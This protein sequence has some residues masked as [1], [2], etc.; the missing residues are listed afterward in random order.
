MHCQRCGRAMTPYEAAELAS[1]A[2]RCA[3][4]APVE[5]CGMIWYCD[6]CYYPIVVEA[7]NALKRGRRAAE[8]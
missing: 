4:A 3:F 5:A 8:E 7:T 2:D 6:N 1:Q